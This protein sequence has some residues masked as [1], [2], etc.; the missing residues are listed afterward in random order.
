V[1]ALLGKYADRRIQSLVHVEF[2]RPPDGAR[3][4]AFETHLID[5][6][7]NVHFLIGRGIDLVKR[8]LEFS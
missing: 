1:I 6:L 4:D 7:G 3:R 8:I 5:L 2:A